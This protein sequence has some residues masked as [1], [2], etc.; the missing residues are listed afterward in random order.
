MRIARATLLSFCPAALICGASVAA[1]QVVPLTADPVQ[2]NQQQF[3]NEVIN[4]SVNTTTLFASQDIFSTGRFVK[5]R[6]DQPDT[7]YDTARTPFE[8]RLSEKTD[9]W[10]P[11]VYG[12]GAL[13]KVSSGAS[14]PPGADGEDDFSTGKLFAVA[15]GMGSYLRV[16]DD[17]KLSLS[18]ALAFSHLTNRYDFNNSY[19]QSVLEPDNKLY[20]NWNMNLFTYTPTAKAIYESQWGDSIANVTLAY[21]QLFND[22]IDSSSPAINIDSASGILWSRVSYSEP[23]GVEMLNADTRIRPY[24]QW[25][26]ISGK[27]AKGLDLVNLYEMGADVVFDFKEKVLVFSQM[28]WGGSYVTGDS[29]EGYHIGFGGKF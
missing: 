17:F 20:Y 27:A 23:T 21:S 6:I 25:S 19:S 14:K 24:F 18:C 8:I 4:E 28:Y 22:S 1:A 29:F 13:L 3:A 11:Y 16:S 26:N 5:R 12:S 2:G 9:R 7:H 10:Q 15:A